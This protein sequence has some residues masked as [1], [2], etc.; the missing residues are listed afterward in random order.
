MGNFGT[1]ASGFGSGAT[2]GISG[3]ATRGVSCLVIRRRFHINNLRSFW[4]RGFGIEM[5]II[6]FWQIMVG[7]E[8]EVTVN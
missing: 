8:F 5:N 7:D 2:R 3:L 4:S 6:A 1:R